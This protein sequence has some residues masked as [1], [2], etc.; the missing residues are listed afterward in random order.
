MDYTPC[1]A[2]LCSPCSE[3]R[4]AL[5]ALFHSLGVTLVP[6]HNVA[7]ASDLLRRRHFSLA[8]LDLDCDP[9][10]T[11]TI[12]RLLAVDPQLTVIV[13][14]RLPDEH[15]WIDA[16]EAGAADFISKPFSKPELDWVLETARHLEAAI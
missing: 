13:Y 1:V 14:S 10:W 3:D 5:A 4:A 12:E 11:E 8:L 15:R 6:A 7:T 16:L 9:A 2:L